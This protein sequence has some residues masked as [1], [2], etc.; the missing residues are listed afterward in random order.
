MLEIAT[1]ANHAHKVKSL[2]Q[3]ELTASSQD[4]LATVTRLL[5]LTTNAKIA[6][7]INLPIKEPLLVTL[8]NNA[9]RAMKLEVMFK[10]ATDAMLAH[11]DNSLMRLELDA[12]HQD[13][14][15]HAHQLLMLRTSVKVAQCSKLLT[16]VT[17]SVFQAQ[18]AKVTVNILEL[19]KTATDVDNANKDG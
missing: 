4:Q 10:A 7:L 17:T 6:Q 18:A 9:L 8:S 11:K 1:D 5:V 2:M 19:K 14:S 13:Q 12:I 15:A 16:M 3:P